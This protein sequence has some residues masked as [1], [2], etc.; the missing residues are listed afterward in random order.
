VHI[1][2]L[3]T[4]TG[5]EEF[6]PLSNAEDDDYRELYHVRDVRQLALAFAHH[7]QSVVKV[8]R[9]QKPRTRPPRP[10]LDL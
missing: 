6:K 4:T 1:V 10:L 9:L 3:R 8:D 7:C 2:L 5:L